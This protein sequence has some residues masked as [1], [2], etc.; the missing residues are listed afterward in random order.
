MTEIKRGGR[1]RE[2]T[3][4]KKRRKTFEGKRSIKYVTERRGR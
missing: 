4:D 2:L 3:K 1:D